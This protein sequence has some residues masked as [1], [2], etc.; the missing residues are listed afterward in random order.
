[1]PSWAHLQPV[2]HLSKARHAGTGPSG[3]DAVTT[4]GALDKA[5]ALELSPNWDYVA[6][7][8]MGGVSRGKAEHAVIDGRACTRLTGTVS[9]DNNGG[10]VQIAFDPGNGDGFDAGAYTGIGFDVFGNGET[11]DIRVRTRALSRPWQSFRAAFGAPPAWT[12]VRIPFDGL[13]PYR[14]SARFQATALRRI[15]IL[16]IGREMQADIAVT[17]LQFYR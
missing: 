12:A 13:V 5:P 4:P 10:F 8:V 16:A 17:S 1:M 2:R 6:D 7:T 15:G 3:P 11:Y 9:L 14:T